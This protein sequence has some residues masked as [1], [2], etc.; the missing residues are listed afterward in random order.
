MLKVDE[1]G[2]GVYMVEPVLTWVVVLERV[3]AVPQPLAELKS[4]ECNMRLR[5]H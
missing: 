1:A 2:L 4:S 5:N 3:M